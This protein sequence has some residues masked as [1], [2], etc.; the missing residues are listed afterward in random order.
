MRGRW[1]TLSGRFEPLILTG[2]PVEG[3]QDYG[4]QESQPFEQA[5]EVVAGGGENGVGGVALVSGEVFRPM[6]CSALAWPMTGSTAERRRSSRLM[7]S[8]TRRLWPEI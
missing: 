5:S 7:V 3:G 1:G 2:R 4:Q 8:V 6:R